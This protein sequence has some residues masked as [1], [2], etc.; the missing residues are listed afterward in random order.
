[1]HNVVIGQFQFWFA[2]LELTEY[3]MLG[4]SLEGHK[5]VH[6]IQHTTVG[7]DKFN[8]HKVFPTY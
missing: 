7:R 3:C 1:M 4:H 2:N 5:N 8:T 6:T